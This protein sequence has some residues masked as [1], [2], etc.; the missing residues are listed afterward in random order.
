MH[1]SIENFLRNTSILHF[2]LQNYLQFLISFPYICYI[3]IFV[4]KIG[5]VVSKEKMLK[6]DGRQLIGPPLSINRLK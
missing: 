3:Q 5:P 1:W 4:V 2:L 6:D